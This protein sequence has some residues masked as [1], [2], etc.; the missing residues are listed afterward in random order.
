MKNKNKND[1]AHI[2]EVAITTKKSNLICKKIKLFYVCGRFIIIR[3]YV[4]V[5]CLVRSLRQIIV[6][7]IKENFELVSEY[8]LCCLHRL[9]KSKQ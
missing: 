9:F 2:E 5:F 8:G 7:H 1:Y 4:C 6:S 3:L